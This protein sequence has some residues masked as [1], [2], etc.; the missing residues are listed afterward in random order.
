M[1]QAVPVHSH[2]QLIHP[3]RHTGRVRTDT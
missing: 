2:L 3:F 1:R